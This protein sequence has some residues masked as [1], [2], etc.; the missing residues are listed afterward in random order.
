M[1]R[2]GMTVTHLSNPVVAA[3]LTA[4]ALI[5]LPAPLLAQDR[6]PPGGTRECFSTPPKDRVNT[7]EHFLCPDGYYVRG[8]MMRH[9]FGE[10]ATYQEA[11]S[12][13]C[14]PLH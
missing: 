13:L 7:T 8:M 5:V 9:R 2:P 10:N 11:I 3:I 1:T 12:L 6:G 4:V 14:C